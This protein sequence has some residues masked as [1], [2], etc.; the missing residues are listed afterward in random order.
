VATFWKKV[1]MATIIGLSGEFIAISYIYCLKFLFASLKDESAHYTTGIWM[2]CAYAL[3]I[4]MTITLRN[5]LYFHGY[6]VAVTMRKVIMTA[7]YG[8]VSKLSLKSLAETNSGKLITIISSEMFTIERYSAMLPMVIMCPFI[9]ALCM[10]YIAIEEGV[11]YAVITMVGFIFCVGGQ[12]LCNHFAKNYKQRES[13][14]S[15]QRMK[16]ISDMVT[17]IRTI[18]SYA[19]ENHY[20]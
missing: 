16:L 3:A 18:K 6:N 2:V 20:L 14:L 8:K 15:D 17:G 13:Y 9:V 7:L 1:L 19:W 4:L 11:I 10:V 12:T 5:Q